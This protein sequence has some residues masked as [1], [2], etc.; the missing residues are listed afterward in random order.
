MSN[1]IQSLQP[2]DLAAIIPEIG[3]LVLAILVMVFDLIWPTSRKRNLGFL[4]AGGLV[5]I[6]AVLL[7]VG[8]PAD[9]PE[10]AF[11]G[12]VRHSLR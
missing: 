3:L 6:L 5:I 9:E 7:T 4:T 10:G 8:Y 11:G 12:M 1:I 2:S